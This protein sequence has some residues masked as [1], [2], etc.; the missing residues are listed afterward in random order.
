MKD[1]ELKEI[2]EDI[3]R[4]YI[5]FFKEVG[6]KNISEEE[7]QYRRGSRDAYKYVID[8]FED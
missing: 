6:E 5:W 1:D 3:K 4:Q 7:K 8:Q 2:I